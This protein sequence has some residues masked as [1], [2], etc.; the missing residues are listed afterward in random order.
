M[1]VYIL[2]FVWGLSTVALAFP[3]VAPTKVDGFRNQ[4]T[5]TISTSSPT[6]EG[7]APITNAPIQATPNGEDSGGL[8]G[9]FTFTQSTVIVNGTIDYPVH[10]T[11]RPYLNPQGLRAVMNIRGYAR[12]VTLDRFRVHGPFTFAQIEVMV[13]HNNRLKF[14]Q[15]H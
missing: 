2:L 7:I 11:S 1:K 12:M 8:V 13:L 5:A 10:I 9:M 14:A 6:A 4:A 3:I 15:D